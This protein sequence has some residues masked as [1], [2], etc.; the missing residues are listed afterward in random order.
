MLL[1][2]GFFWLGPVYIEYS[3]LNDSLTQRMESGR[4]W[5]GAKMRAE[6]DDMI[7][8]SELDDRLLPSAEEK[9]RRLIIVG[10]VHGCIEESESFWIGRCS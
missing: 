5:F 8:Q 6:F 9:D 3:M 10:D 4:G 2:A 1:L 7:Q